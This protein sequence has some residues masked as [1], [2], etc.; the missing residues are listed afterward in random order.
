MKKTKTKAPYGDVEYADPGY[1]G[2]KKY[3]VDTPEH[4]RAAWSYI[5]QERD[6]G[7]YTAEQ[8]ASVRAAIVAAW[9]KHVDPK[10]PPG[11]SK[12]AAGST[13]ADSRDSWDEGSHPRAPKGQAGGGR[14]VGGETPEGVDQGHVDSTWHPERSTLYAGRAP[15]AAQFGASYG[16]VSDDAQAFIDH[17]GEDFL[18]VVNEVENE[19]GA[20]PQLLEDFMTEMKLSDD[21]GKVLTA[22]HQSYVGSF[23]DEEAAAT[24][25]IHE[26]YAHL[27][28]GLT[29]AVDKSAL[30]DS[31]VHD[32]GAPYVS[33]S[34]TDGNLWVFKRPR[35]LAKDAASGEDSTSLIGV[36]DELTVFDA[37]ANVH[38]T[39]DG[40][41]AASPRIARTGIQVY[42]GWEMGVPEKETV[43]IYRPEKEVFAPDSLRSYAHKPVT[44][45][46]PKEAVTS[47]N[48]RKYAVGHTADE[49]LRDGGFI[50]IPIMISDAN[51]I[52]DIEEGKTQLSL[53]YTM[54]LDW[55]PGKAPNGEAYD[56]VQRN[57]RANHLALVAAARGGKELR[58][59]DSTEGT[60]L[61][62]K[63]TVDNASFDVDDAAAVVIPRHVERLEKGVADAAVALKTAQDAAAKDAATIA[64]LTAEN[65]TLKKKVE[66]AKLTPQQIEQLV[67]D[68]AEVVGLARAVLGDKVVTDGREVSDIKRQVVDSAMGATAKSWNEEQVASSFAVLTKDAKVGEQR[69]ARD[70]L[71]RALSNP[72]V[73]HNAQQ[74]LDA[75][76]EEYDASLRNS[77]KKKTAA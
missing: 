32:K 54:E 48:W 13:R 18:P 14:F 68:R 37:G 76:Y 6:A 23:E 71:T 40:Y 28:K 9:K 44:N 33:V 35:P 66:D 25:F 27:P 41:L 46:H 21:P 43:R 16:E 60:T 7:K 10:G 42:K 30:F 8:L 36:N 56:G 24:D 31:L 38:R 49:I 17:H 5:N 69:E 22:F 26:S 4:V 61:M 77:W 73:P 58:V 65:A 20:D 19:Y 55:T 1:N 62:K 72:A 11:A 63:I 34:D 29:G 75:A 57:I 53:G 64:T 2:T 59:G 70:G 67:R 12:D 3:P 47:D 51:T 74:T 50:R 52:Q 15:D 45:D 39:A